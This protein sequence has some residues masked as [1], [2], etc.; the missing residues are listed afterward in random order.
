MLSDALV[1]E[2]LKNQKIDDIIHIVICS[3]NEK[4][5]NPRF[6][7]KLRENSSI[8]IFQHQLASQASGYKRLIRYKLRR[9][10]LTGDI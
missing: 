3:E 8:T 7:F 5:V 10:F 2:T 1:I 4:N 6:I 9:S